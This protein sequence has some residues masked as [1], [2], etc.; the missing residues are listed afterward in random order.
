M[1]THN[2]LLLN[3]KF[4]FYSF[5]FHPR[6]NWFS[7]C[8]QSFSICMKKPQPRYPKQYT[9]YVFNVHTI[10]HLPQH[11]FTAQQSPCHRQRKIVWKSIIIDHYALLL[12]PQLS[13]FSIRKINGVPPLFSLKNAKVFQHIHVA[14]SCSSFYLQAYSH[15][16]PSCS[17]EAVRPN[18]E[19]ED[20]KVLKYR[21]CY[22]GSHCDKHTF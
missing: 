13:S 6:W 5:V 22:S 15:E 14:S 20:V 19:D 2:L 21:V 17:L 3:I 1:Y 8:V 4:Y 7:V 10:I 12:H 9:L 18:E 11:Q 16:K